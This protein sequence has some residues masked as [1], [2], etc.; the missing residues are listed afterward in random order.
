MRLLTG[1]NRGARLQLR[2]VDI[3]MEMTTRSTFLAMTLA[4]SM[5]VGNVLADPSAEVAWLMKEP[6]TLFDQGIKRID[7]HLQIS[8]FDD[9]DPDFTPSPES[10]ASPIGRRTPLVHYFYEENRIRLTLEIELKTGSLATVA[11]CQSELLENQRTFF[12]EEQITDEVLTH[13]NRTREQQLASMARKWFAHEGYRRSGEPAGLD[14]AI[15]RIMYLEVDLNLPDDRMP[16][17]SCSM[18][19][20]G[21]DVKIVVRH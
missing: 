15:A 1:G 17:V 9:S 20:V 16:S 13:R 14:E 10:A 21:G 5:Y 11:L 3:H 2:R 4:I 19:L 6:V 12:L 8:R 18:P 7:E